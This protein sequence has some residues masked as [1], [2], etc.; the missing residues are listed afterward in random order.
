MQTLRVKLNLPATDPPKAAQNTFETISEIHSD[1]AIFQ[2]NQ[3]Q[4][5]DSDDWGFRVTYR[6]NGTF[7]QTTSL[8]ELERTM[9]N[10]ADNS[11]EQRVHA[12]GE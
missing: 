4:Y 1:Q 11:F 6:S 9:A 10:V 2:V 7:V 5:L 12:E 3:T 8:A